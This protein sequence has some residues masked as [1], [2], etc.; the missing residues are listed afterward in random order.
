MRT[1]QTTKE[2]RHGRLGRLLR[3]RELLLQI[4]DPVLGVVQAQILDQHSLGEIVGSIRL[5]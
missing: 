1:E 4:G 5:L 3:V 2:T